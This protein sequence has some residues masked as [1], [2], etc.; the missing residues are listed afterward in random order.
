M[1]EQPRR[2]EHFHLVA[3]RSHVGAAQECAPIATA[4]RLPAQLAK[5]EEDRA[6]VAIRVCF[7]ERRSDHP[8]YVLARFCARR[9][10]FLSRRSVARTRRCFAWIF[11][12]RES[13]ILGMDFHPHLLF[14][15]GRRARHFEAPHPPPG[16]AT[17]VHLSAVALPPP[18][19]PQPRPAK[20][21]APPAEW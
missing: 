7:G 6:V 21:V 13:V 18:G 20:G 9:A 5:W 3:G 12:R 10:A 16:S 19:A 15:R 14:F 11:L 4:V 17:P 8:P 1:V 2:D